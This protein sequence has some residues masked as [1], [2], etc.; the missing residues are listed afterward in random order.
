MRMATT[1]ASG[2]CHLLPGRHVYFGVRKKFSAAK[3]LLNCLWKSLVFVLST[4]LTVK[5]TVFRDVKSQIYQH[6]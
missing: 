6:D 4:T 2:V 5:M 1:W 3:C